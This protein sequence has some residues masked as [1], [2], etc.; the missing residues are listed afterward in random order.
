MIFCAG[1]GASAKAA[2]PIGAI[3]P[4]SPIL[5]NRAQSARADATQKRSRK[6]SEIDFESI[7]IHP[8]TTHD[9]LKNIS[10]LLHKDSLLSDQILS[11]KAYTKLFGAS[12]GRLSAINAKYSGF[13]GGSS[14]VYL[15][16]KPGEASAEEKC[17]VQINYFKYTDSGSNRAIDIKIT[18]NSKESCSIN[19]DNIV[20]IFGSYWNP[21]RAHSDP[22]MDS[23]RPAPA[24]PNGNTTI[25][26]DF[27][28]C[29][30]QRQASFAF[31]ENAALSE[32]DITN[33]ETTCRR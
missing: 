15:N 1:G 23:R 2:Q 16:G 32:A 10:Q 14:G 19:F 17:T 11:N 13:Q 20:S 18:V 26:Y 12:E 22:L 8:H 27:S 7:A 4:T 25:T 5:A 6:D 3:G 29:D 24:R 21:E 30:H 33:K 28:E 31:D 9:L